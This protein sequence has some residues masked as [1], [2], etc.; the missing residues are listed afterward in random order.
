M[1]RY[2]FCTEKVHNNHFVTQNDSDLMEVESYRAIEGMFTPSQ[3][4]P[5]IGHMPYDKEESNDT[6]SV[7][8]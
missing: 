6:P 7:F 8:H 5:Y 3:S 2:L 4:P 1:L